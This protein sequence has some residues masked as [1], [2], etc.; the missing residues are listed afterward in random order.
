MLPQDFQ[1][2]PAGFSLL[3]TGLRHAKRAGR[4]GKASGIARVKRRIGDTLFKCCDFRR[5]LFHPCRQGCQFVLI[6]RAPALLAQ[7]WFG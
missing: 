2:K 6:Q 5:K 1:F 3:Q 4:L 7:G